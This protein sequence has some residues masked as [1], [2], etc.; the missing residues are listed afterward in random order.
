MNEEEEKQYKDNILQ[1]LNSGYIESIILAYELAKSIKF[2]ITNH[3]IHTYGHLIFSIEQPT[4]LILKL[5]RSNQTPTP[6]EIQTQLIS[7]LKQ[8]N[9]NLRSK[10]LSHIPN[11]IHLLFAATSIDLSGNHIEHIHPNLLKTHAKTINLSFNAINNIPEEL[12][13]IH[14]LENIFLQ[15]NSI[16]FPKVNQIGENLTQITIN[17]SNGLDN[18][19]EFK[20]KFPNVIV[21]SN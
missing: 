21:N 4:Q 6:K 17:P 5:H 12:F 14:T 15:G 10:M 7:L 19:L 9:V 20:N 3:V 16:I 8:T 13:Q 2:D 1:L 11:N 18:L